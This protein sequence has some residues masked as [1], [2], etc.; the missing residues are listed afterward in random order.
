[1]V[2][3]YR[4]LP[5]GFLVLMFNEWSVCSIIHMA[6]LY[7]ESFSRRFY[8]SN[9][10]RVV[11]M[12]GVSERVCKAEIGGLIPVPLGSGVKTHLKPQATANHLSPM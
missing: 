9:L 2:V 3:V 8:Q 1:M 5:A 11:Q 10:Q 6:T 7:I 4:T 12:R